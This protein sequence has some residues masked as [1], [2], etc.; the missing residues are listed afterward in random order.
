MKTRICPILLISLLVFSL[1]PLFPMGTGTSR[2]TAT[3]PTWN[4]GDFWEYNEVYVTEEMGGMGK[5]TYNWNNRVK[6]TLAGTTTYNG[7]ACYNL[8]I[9]GTY[10]ATGSM[11]KAGTYSGFRLIRQSDLAMVYEYRYEDG[12]G[13]G[14]D[15]YYHY[16][17]TFAPVEDY[18]SFPIEPDGLPDTWSI[19]TTKTVHKVGQAPGISVNRKKHATINMAAQCSGTETKTVPAASD[20]ECYK[21]TASGGSQKDNRWYSV[22]YGTFLN[23]DYEE[24]YNNTD[25]KKGNEELFSTSLS[26]NNKPQVSMFSANP[27]TVANDDIET[28]VLKVKVIDG[29]GL[30]ASDPVI[31]DLS[32]IGGESDQEMY[33]DGTHGDAIAGDDFYSF[34]TTVPTDVDPDDYDLD[35][36][37]TDDEGLFNGT[38]FIT[39]TVVLRN[40]PPVIAQTQADPSEIPNDGTT[41]VL[42]SA[43]VTDENTALDKILEEVTIDLSNIGGNGDV[44]MRDDG[45]SGDI[46][47]DD[48]IFSIT[49]KV[50]TST[51]PGTHDLML[52]ATDKADVKTFDNISLTV[53]I[54]NHPPVLSNPKCEPDTVPNDGATEALLTID[55]NDEDVEDIHLVEID[56]SDLGGSSFVAM[57]DDGKD[58]DELAQDGTYSCLFAVST[59][60]DPGEYNLL[61][62]A[63]DDGINPM[64]VFEN[65][66]IT[67]SEQLHTPVIKKLTLSHS[68]VPNDGTTGI[69]LNAEVTDEDDNLDK[70][71]VDLTPVGGLAQEGM[72]DDD[73]DGTYTIMI[74]VSGIVEPGE[75]S[76]NV[77]AVDT[78]GLKAEKS[79]D[80]LVEATQM[81]N[82][83]P[84]VTKPM[85][86]PSS[87]SNDGESEVTLSVIIE[88]E[89]GIEDIF[90]VTIDLGEIGGDVEE[91]EDDG[92]IDDDNRR[93]YTYKFKVPRKTAPG[94]YELPVTVT[95]GKVADGRNEIDDIVIDI[96][97]TEANAGDDDTGKGDS[98]T[99]DSG[100]SGTTIGIIIGVVLL[101][102]I[103]V[104]ILVIV[105]KRK[106]KDEKVE[107]E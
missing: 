25:T 33:D 91:M 26:V 67:V 17:I 15:Y 6:Y 16:Y 21:I 96:T 36:T 30:A 57:T 107:F 40:F 103:I 74:V 49:V 65:I 58:G 44:D 64:N 79:I 51:V 83:V 56:L 32:S 22:D 11:N 7:H 70:V 78:D 104:V 68:K 97:I 105:L 8:T 81:F 59:D 34:E 93:K 23:A 5:T 55:L 66:T 76:L 85:A 20:V 53:I 89:N 73:D 50:G 90:E 71:F 46:A 61:V 100:G 94:D 35:I 52:T 28:T 95:D 86:D 3:V 47:A 98:G 18:Y 72:T 43:K 9:S 27:D 4:N 2:G 102:V 82:Y 48:D 12:A 1:I 19:M 45:Q 69:A 37:A 77:T 63:R 60:T 31:I 106:K 38:E 75:Y 92:S 29:E 84:E 99:K 10:A 24:T 62:T 13:G 42:L 41:E 14:M 80:L 101:I 39:L 88:D 54:A 87:I